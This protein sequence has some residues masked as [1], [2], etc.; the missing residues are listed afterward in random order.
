MAKK[1]TPRSKQ[2]MLKRH[3][4]KKKL[5]EKLKENASDFVADRIIVDMGDD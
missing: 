2:G 5:E 1:Q 4:L 3:E